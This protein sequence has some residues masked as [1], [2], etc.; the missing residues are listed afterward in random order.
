M[1]SLSVALTADDSKKEEMVKLVRSH[2]G[3]LAHVRLVATRHTGQL[4]EGRTGLPVERLESGLRGGH[5]HIGALVASGALAA[6]I[7]L[8]DPLM[9]QPH[10]PDAASLMRVCDVCNIPIATNLACAESVLHFLLEHEDSTDAS[11]S[12]SAT[13]LEICSVR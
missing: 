5:L 11:G 12:G 13:S 8:R 6:V 7:F 2:L 3:S 1:K 10:E 9:A 4:V